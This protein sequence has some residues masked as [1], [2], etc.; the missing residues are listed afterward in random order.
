MLPRFAPERVESITG[1]ARADV[2]RLAHRYGRARAPFIRIGFGMSRSAQG[3]QATRAVALLPGVTGAYAPRAAAA[4]LLA[5]GAGFGLDFA[6]LRRPSGPVAHAPREPL[7]AGRRAPDVARAADPRAVRRGEQP[8]G[9][10][11]DA[12]AVRRGLSREDLFTV[13]HD[14]F[15]SDTAALRGHRAAGD[16][17]PRDGGFLPRLWRLLHAVRPARRPAAGRSAIEPRPGAGAGAAARRDGSDLLDDDRRAG[18]ADVREGDRP[19]GDDRSRVAPRGRPGEG[20]AR[21]PT[22][23]LRHAVGEA[24]V[25]LGAARGPGPSADAG[26]GAGRGGR[27]RR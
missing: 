7:A 18:G 11:S 15:I 12:Q 4:R 17:V 21:I 2:E 9:D 8:G 13:V 5:T 3:G 26:L 24:R 14:P 10:V 1:V 23:R 20:D 16:D 22:A 25:L 27:R 19:R 6:R